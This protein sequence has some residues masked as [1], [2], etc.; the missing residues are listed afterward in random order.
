MGKK[1]NL[2]HTGNKEVYNLLLHKLKK[3]NHDTIYEE[4][5]GVMFYKIYKYMFVH[6][7]IICIYA[8]I[9]AHAF[10]HTQKDILNAHT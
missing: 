10:K 2:Q 4:P 6:T 5:K 3:E 1:K 9:H 7:Y 8:E